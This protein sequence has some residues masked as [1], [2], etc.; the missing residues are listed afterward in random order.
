MAKGLTVDINNYL[1]KNTGVATDAV[2]PVETHI[3]SLF[4][5]DG[6]TISNEGFTEVLKRF[7][8]WLT[9]DGKPGVGTMSGGWFKQRDVIIASLKKTYLNPEWLSKRTI[10]AGT[11]IRL[12]RSYDYIGIGGLIQTQDLD[13]PVG[14]FLEKLR[15]VSDAYS[16][17]LR[18]IDIELKRILHKVNHFDVD[19]LNLF[20]VEDFREA[21]EKSQIRM[22]V[23]YRTTFGNTHVQRVLTIMADS[24]KPFN[25]DRLKE[26]KRASLNAEE[27]VTCAG[28]IIKVSESLDILANLRKDF[29]N[30]K[31][32]G[33]LKGFGEQLQQYITT[34]ESLEHRDK[35]VDVEAHKRMLDLIKPVYQIPNRMLQFH[36]LHVD[37]IIRAYARLIDASVK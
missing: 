33:H 3:N 11:P 10:R 19:A 7:W 17:Y 34:A 16:E 9:E 12:D 23:N 26:D 25:A 4:G 2:V 13:G 32:F 1:D 8:L 22:T 15:K 20:E 36:L 5:T 24:D 30:L 27:I 28:A 37:S 35:G 31:S 18:H 6:E 29:Y 21:L 14:D